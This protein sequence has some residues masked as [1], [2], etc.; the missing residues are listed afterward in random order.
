VD[1]QQLLYFLT[2]AR[3]EHMGAAA[4][5]L[6]ISESALSRSIARLERTHGVRLFDRVGRGIRLNPYGRIVAASVEAAFRALD[7]GRRELESLVAAGSEPVA[8]G[9][10]PSLGPHVVPALLAAD[11]G[12]RRV[13]LVQDSAEHLR[14]ALLDGGLDLTLGTLRYDDAAV[15]WRPLW[16]EGLIAV[17]PAHHPAT[18]R[19]EAVF[20]DVAADR[21]LTPRSSVSTDAAIAAAARA[22]DVSPNIVFRCDDASTLSGLVAAGYGTAIVPANVFVPHEGVTAVR[23]PSLGARTIGVAASRSKPLS[24]A[25]EA[26]RGTIVQA[27]AGGRSPIDQRRSG[28]S[29]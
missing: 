16:D 18:R 5:E 29:F 20:P 10:L 28:G 27:C 21:L 19:S 25:A 2:T 17:V 9:F 6:G 22:A 12:K 24:A 8:L 14:A 13:R 4:A 11:A 23:L 15:D 7:D 1:R 3:R 26:F